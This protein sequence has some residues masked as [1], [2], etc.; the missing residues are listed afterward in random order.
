M[1]L[2]LPVALTVLLSLVTVAFAGPTNIGG[3]TCG[4]HP[5]AEDI[6]AN[7]N[8][9]ADALSKIG[10][11]T[12]LTGNYSNRTIQVHFNVIYSG[13]KLEQGYVP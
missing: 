6:N 7:E 12:R 9:F 3:R 2:H 5:T 10:S 1:I 4:S 11:S 13:K 8:K